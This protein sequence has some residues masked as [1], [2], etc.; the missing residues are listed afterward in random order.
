[1]DKFVITQNLQENVPNRASQDQLISMSKS[2]SQET[3]FVNKV[4]PVST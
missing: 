4:V 3:N 1:M 2:S